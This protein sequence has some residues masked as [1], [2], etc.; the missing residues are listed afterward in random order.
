MKYTGVKATEEETEECLK[1][2]IKASTTPMI[3]THVSGGPSAWAWEATRK[4]CHELA[5][6]HGLPEIKGYYGMTG[7]GEFVEVD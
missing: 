4:R 2:V 5:L 1:L 3:M 7:D 6:A